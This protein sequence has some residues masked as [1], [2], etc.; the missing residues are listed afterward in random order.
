MLIQKR[1]KENVKPQVYR[2][3]NEHTNTVYVRGTDMQG[4][5]VQEAQGGFRGNWQVLA[6]IVIGS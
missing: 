5:T 1:K 2:H 4:I 3:G 6:G